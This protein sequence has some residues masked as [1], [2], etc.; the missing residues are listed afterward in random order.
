MSYLFP[1]FT[2]MPRRLEL[3][4]SMARPMRVDAALHTVTP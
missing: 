2:G 4:V 1:V 3:T